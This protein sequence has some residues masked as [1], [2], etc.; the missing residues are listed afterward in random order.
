MPPPLRPRGRAAATADPAVAAASPGLGAP[1][2]VAR[3]WNPRMPLSSS[4]YE[5]CHRN[6]TELRFSPEGTN[7]S[8]YLTKLLSTRWLRS[9]ALQLRTRCV[10]PQHDR[11]VGSRSTLSDR[12]WLNLPRESVDAR[13]GAVTGFAWARDNG[14]IL[15]THDLD[16][17][18]VLAS[19]G[20]G[21]QSVI[22][23]RASDVAQHGAGPLILDVLILSLIHI[24]EPT[25]LGMISYA[26]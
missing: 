12:A 13:D 10:R 23:L 1:G 25:R 18:A 15:L 20:A 3:T 14:R 8:P 26:V 24:S 4:G 19:S 21:S 22:Q 2:A 11:H 17:G 5:R 9:W 7:T 16:F 6:K